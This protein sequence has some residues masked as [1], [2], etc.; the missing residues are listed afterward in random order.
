MS[1]VWKAI[2][3][4]LTN[5]IIRRWLGGKWRRRMPSLSKQTDYFSASTSARILR[6]ESGWNRD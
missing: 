5:R 1:G 4:A 2:A 6:A 3:G